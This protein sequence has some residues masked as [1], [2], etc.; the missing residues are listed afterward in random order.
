MLYE[1][2]SGE[3]KG[4]I[5]SIE[6]GKNPNLVMFYPVEGKYPYRVCVEKS[7]VSLVQESS[8]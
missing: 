2:I 8:K 4:R 7:Q 1:I 3:Y 5:G 6:N